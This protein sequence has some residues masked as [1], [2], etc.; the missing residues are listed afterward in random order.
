MTRSKLTITILDRW[1]RP[2]Y[3]HTEAATKNAATHHPQVGGGTHP[4]VG[5]ITKRLI[6]CTLQP[7]FFA[8][9]QFGGLGLGGRRSLSEGLTFSTMSS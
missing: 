8:Y 6:S 4:R 7:V 5:Q 3:Q 2:Y 1:G 9:P